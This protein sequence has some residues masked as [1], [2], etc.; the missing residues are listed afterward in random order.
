MKETSYALTAADGSSASGNLRIGQTV[1]GQY[2]LAEQLRGS[3]PILSYS[4]QQVASGERVILKAVPR[5]ATSR[6]T[7]GESKRSDSPVASP[8][9]LVLFND[10]GWDGDWFYAVR[11]YIEGRSLSNHL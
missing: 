1:A 8:A 2:V 10:V 9:A 6:L 4:A 11:P 3:G 7:R 5:R